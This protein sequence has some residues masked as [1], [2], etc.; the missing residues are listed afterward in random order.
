MFQRF[1]SFF[2]IKYI[3]PPFQECVKNNHDGQPAKWEGANRLISVSSSNKLEKKVKLQ[4]LYFKMRF[5]VTVYY[6]QHMKLA[7]KILIIN[8][9]CLT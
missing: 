8:K 5:T 7:M 9:L 4:K 2:K 1:Q 3:F 6:E